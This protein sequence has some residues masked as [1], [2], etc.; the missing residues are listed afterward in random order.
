MKALGDRKK[1]LGFTLIELLVVIAIIAI[2]AALLLPALSRSKASAYRVKCMSNLRQ[3]GLGLCIY[4]DDFSRYPLYHAPI[5][6]ATTLVWWYEALEPYTRSK[7]WQPLYLCPTFKGQE[8]SDPKYRP[9]SGT[10][11]WRNPMVFSYGYNV[12]GV[13]FDIEPYGFGLGGRTIMPDPPPLPFSRVVVPS[14]MIAFGDSYASGYASG[15]NSVSGDQPWIGSNLPGAVDGIVPELRW[16]RAADQRHRRSLNTVF[17][18]GHVESI[19]LKTLLYD[20]SETALRRWNNDN[21]SH[22]ELY[23]Y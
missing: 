21:R 9:Y 17:C 5:P 14:D 10:P 18:D 1:G 8:Y 22:R 19:K 15:T 6:Q 7:W 20:R 4:T 12:W 11:D 13:G 23:R 16:G 3:I 2:L